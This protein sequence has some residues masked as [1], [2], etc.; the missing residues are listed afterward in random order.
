MTKS[1]PGP[2]LAEASFTEDSRGEPVP[3]GE[4]RHSADP[5]GDAG[6][7]AAEL[8]AATANVDALMLTAM[9]ALVAPSDSAGC[10]GALAMLRA[11]VAG[12]QD[13]P[14]AAMRHR[15]PER[16]TPKPVPLWHP[17]DPDLAAAAAAVL[18]AQEDL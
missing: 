5:G 17:I 12:T 8:V 13:L 2:A 14:L 7:S 18:A 3:A 4:R 10:L 1:T 16:P 11:A 15:R 9:R 6:I